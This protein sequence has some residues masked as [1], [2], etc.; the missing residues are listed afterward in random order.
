MK[1]GWKKTRLG[2]ACE[3]ISRGIAPSYVN[4]GGIRVVNQKCIRY[5][6]I[7]Y[8]LSRR[9]DTR[10]K[11][12]PS[13]RIIRI[14][15]VLVNSTGTGTLGRVAQ[16]RQ[17]PGE[18]TTVDTHVSIVR[19]KMGQFVP[20]F[21]GYMLIQIEDQLIAGGLG[22]SGQ[23]EL[24]RSD[25]ESKFEVSYPVL[26]EEQQRIVDILDEAFEGLDRARANAEA[27]LQ[28][29]W[30]LFES[31]REDYLDPTKVSLWSLRTLQDLVNIKHGF[32][33]K[34]E[35]F[36]DHGEYAV[37]TPGNYYETGGFRDRAG[38]QRYYAGD[39]PSEFLLKKG[40][41]LMAMTEQAPGLLGSCILVPSDK[42]FLHNQRLGLITPKE[43]VAWNPEFFAHAFNLMAFRQAL[44]D[45]CS[46]AT[47]RHTSPGRILA[48]AIPYS[49]D[50][51]TLAEAAS[52]LTEREQDCRNLQTLYK[53]KLNDIAN[54]R[55]SLLQKAFAGEL[56]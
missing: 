44:S 56:T 22:A 41:L 52:A 38:K 23:T 39:F 3:L 36:V 14:G 30:N 4:E 37:L 9:N 29:A 17:E 18:P 47:V 19:P 50:S 1:S 8:A 34:S 11:K 46:G 40:D 49:N 6:R 16:V 42:S 5:H 31:Y 35:F 43:E 21:F 54:L 7:E 48:Q 24:P 26:L 10:S 27:N 15:D 45:T 20:E 25:L 55:Q 12:V 28:D 53:T 51:N 13:E 2:E 33:F 32:A